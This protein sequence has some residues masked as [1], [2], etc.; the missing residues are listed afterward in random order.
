MKEHVFLAFDYFKKYNINFFDS[1][2]L[3]VMEEHFIDTIITND[4]DFK[5]IPDIN[6][7]RPKANKNNSS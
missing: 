2:Y 1:L 3:A 6:V 7:I 5:K 4:K